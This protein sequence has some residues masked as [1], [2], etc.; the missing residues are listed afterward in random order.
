SSI[1]GNHVVGGVSWPEYQTHADMTGRRIDRLRHS[2]G[3]TIA[4]AVI[5][6]AQKRTTLNH[7]ARNSNLRHVRV[8]ALFASGFHTAAAARLPNGAAALLVARPYPAVA[9]SAAHAISIRR[10]LP[11]RGSAFVPIG[12]GVLPGKLA[13]PGIRHR[14]PTRS[15]FLPPG[16]GG[17]IQTATR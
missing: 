7:S 1:D 10:V 15:K 16:I 3:R 6:R 17:M 5:R 4:P 2:G 9:Y 8:I 13:L 14:L 12:T 11:H